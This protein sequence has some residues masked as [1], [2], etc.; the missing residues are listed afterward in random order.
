MK[1]KK[2]IKGSWN[3]P[4]ENK[5][6]SKK[7]FMTFKSKTTKTISLKLYLGTMLSLCFVFALT[8]FVFIQKPVINNLPSNNS[9]VER[10][11]K[12]NSQFDISFGIIDPINPSLE[13]E[14][15]SHLEFCRYDFL[16][17]RKEFA[18][19]FNSLNL[20][21]S[22]VSYKS[23]VL[24]D[25]IANLQPLEITQLNDSYLIYFTDQDYLIIYYKD[26]FIFYDLVNADILFEQFFQK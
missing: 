15:I 19:W 7:S 17:S 20:V 21:K 3:N 22:N 13:A 5:E 11:P 12:P 23:I 16:E 8:I 6:F 24:D 18:S 9:T 26:Y 10:L 4:I 2:L 14:H 25:Y 1:I